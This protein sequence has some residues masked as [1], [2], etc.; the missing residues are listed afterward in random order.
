M[1]ATHNDLI[2]DFHELSECE[3]ALNENKTKET[4]VWPEFKTFIKTIPLS[5]KI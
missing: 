5:Y 3:D 4:H 2:S 1:N